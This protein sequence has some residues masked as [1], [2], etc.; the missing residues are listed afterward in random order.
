MAWQC[1][2]QLTSVY[3]VNGLLKLPSS[4]RHKLINCCLSRN[5]T[6]ALTLSKPIVVRI[7]RLIKSS[8]TMMM[9]TFH[10]LLECKTL[11]LN[12]NHVLTFLPLTLWSNQM[13]LSEIIYPP[14]MNECH[15][16]RNFSKGYI[17][18]IFQPSILRR[19]SFV[20]RERPR[21][22]ALKPLHPE[23]PSCS[24]RCGVH[25]SSKIRQNPGEIHGESGNIHKSEAETLW[26]HAILDSDTGVVK[27]IFVTTNKL[28]TNCQHYNKS[29][30]RENLTSHPPL[31]TVSLKKLS[32]ELGRMMVMGNC[33][34]M[35]TLLVK[36]TIIEENKKHFWL[37]QHQILLNIH[38]ELSTSLECTLR[39]FPWFRGAELKT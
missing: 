4:L 13:N 17:F 21:Q 30:I 33:C 31:S 8:Q 34:S 16:K 26:K 37:E 23:R 2:A 18:Q 36:M 38:L 12:C 39:E 20:F 32:A 1:L 3:Q 11:M 29:T 28:D 22:L 27:G 10:A 24:K 25:Q 9:C 19:P 15:L 35:Q 7:N 6:A 14:K 5:L